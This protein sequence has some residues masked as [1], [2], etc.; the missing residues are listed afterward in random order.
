MG[1]RGC[2]GGEGGCEGVGG[3]QRMVRWGRGGGDFQ[4]VFTC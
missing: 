1:C 3:G 4:L 2:E